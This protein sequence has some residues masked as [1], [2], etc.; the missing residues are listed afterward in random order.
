[1]K[2]ARKLVKKH[3]DV[4]RWIPCS[5]IMPEQ[6]V[7]ILLFAAGEVY[8]GELTDIKDVFDTDIGFMKNGHVTHWMPLPSPPESDVQ[9]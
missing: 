9:E 6:E 4:K 2:I 3:P 7:R 1:M 5:E 8:V